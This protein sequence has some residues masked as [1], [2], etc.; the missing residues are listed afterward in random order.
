MREITSIQAQK[1]NPGRVS[2]FLDG[3]YAF[4]LSRIVAAWLHVGQGL[5]DEKI[6]ALQSQDAQEV[7]YLAALRMLDHQQRTGQEIRKKLS[8]KGYQDDQIEMVMLKLAEAGLIEDA[9]FA[10]QWVENRNTLHPRSRRLIHLELKQKGIEEEEI[11]NALVGSAEDS[12]LATQA[13]M[14]QL[15]RYSSLEWE[16]FR[17]KMSA[18]LL[19][20]GF[21]YGTIAPVVRTVWESVK[22][23]RKLNENE[24]SGE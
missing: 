3:E 12:V 17:K 7:A 1:K 20:R 5:S 21:S 14:Q 4:G 15:R 8:Q 11:Q 24:E 9:Q 13:A 19:R 16:E 10:R 2:I 23:D 22:S 18:F 6:A